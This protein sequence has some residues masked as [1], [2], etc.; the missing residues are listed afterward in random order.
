V[1]SRLFN[2]H[3]GRLGALE[4]AG[5]VLTDLAVR[6]G[7]AGAITHQ[8]T[9]LGIFAPGVGRRHCIARREGNQLGAP[10]IEEWIGA[11]EQ[12]LSALPSFSPSWNADSRSANGPGDALLRN[13]ITGI[14]GC[15]ARAASGQATAPPRVAMNSRRLMMAVSLSH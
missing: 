1:K 13:P 6:P 11:D 14:A 3:I 12:R 9:S 15:C 7:N 10:A 8:A 2:R 4:D 5:D